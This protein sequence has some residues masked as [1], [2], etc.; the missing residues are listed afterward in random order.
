[1]A[2]PTDDDCVLLGNWTVESQKTEMVMIEFKKDGTVTMTYSNAQIK[3]GIFTIDGDVLTITA[4]GA[5][6]AGN[7]AVGDESV[8]FNTY[9]GDAMVFT[10]VTAE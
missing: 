7:F 10:K 6:I 5:S 2:V 9:A 8:T 3:A 1:S 4:S